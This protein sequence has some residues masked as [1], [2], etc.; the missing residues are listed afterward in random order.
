MKNLQLNE[1]GLMQKQNWREA[2]IALPSFDWKQMRR[3]TF[4]AP[5]WVHFGEG[6]I[7][8]GFIAGLQQR[9]L[10][11][12]LESA[13]ILAAETFDDGII[14]R[15][16][17]PHDSMTLLVTLRP[18]GSTDKEVIA[19]VAR[20][21]KAS[22]RF[23]PDWQTL[24][25]AFENPSLQMISFTITEKGY[26]L[27]NMDGQLLEPVRRDLQN[28]P[29][30]PCH[31]MS[32]AAALLFRR[33]Q[34]GAK[35]I[36]FVSMDNC[37]HNG[38]KLRSSVLEIAHGWQEKGWVP[39]KYT[40][41]LEDEGQVSFPWTMI[42]KITPRPSE[43]I[44]RQLEALGL[45]NMAPIVTEKGTYIAPFV[46]AEAPQYLVV[47]DRFP[48]GRPALEAAGVY[49]TDRE[50]VN[51][52]ERMKVTT[53][54]NPLHTGLAIFGCLLGYSL[55][56]DEMRDAD[57]K[58]LAERIGYTEGLPV[59]TDPGILSPKAFLDEVVKQRLPNPFLP[60]T[61]QRIA[62]DTSQKL[63]IR[64]GETL[65]SY[66]ARP[67]LD[68]SSLTAIPLTLA[69]WLRYLLGIDDEGREMP[70]SADPMLPELRAA[71][72]D[73]RF[74]HPDTAGSALDPLLENASLFGVNLRELGL[75]PRV[76]AYLAEMLSGNGAVR[77]TLQKHL[78]S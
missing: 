75:A 9:L 16:D 71:L 58:A 1:Q 47:E 7:F 3:E 43:A 35:P 14:D 65:K 23:L 63:P 15:I 77:R 41:W 30:Q 12:G 39:A 55:I 68:I 70:V 13:G 51:R 11:Q 18:D 45:A 22:P 33:F 40:A 61:P 54:L 17:L 4:A 57:L 27:R 56:A 5:R 19:S 44:A 28:G 42:D 66:A 53:C 74:G 52:T 64:F 73:V 21:L 29:E 49:M 6:N 25:A 69:G 2:Q 59:V 24:C 72:A 34:A 50:T 37:S 26:A 36:A 48:N 8:R 20:G 62:T 60:D 32:V 67:D 38:E 78:H 31:A 10:N 76:K 46:N